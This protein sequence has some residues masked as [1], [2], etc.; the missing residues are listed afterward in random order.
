M[1]TPTER[2]YLLLGPL[3]SHPCSRNRERSSEVE[4]YVDTVYVGFDGT[5]RFAMKNVVVYNYALPT[6]AQ[7][8]GLVTT[9]AIN[10]S[11]TTKQPL[12][13]MVISAA[14]GKTKL[15]VWGSNTCAINI[16]P[17]T[18]IQGVNGINSTSAP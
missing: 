16:W 11:E 15:R 8:L 18:Y 4:G 6:C 7:H 5:I 3:S 2:V 1:M 13:D 12:R 10:P 9:F 14:D 17:L